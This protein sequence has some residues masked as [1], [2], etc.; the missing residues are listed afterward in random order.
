M[1]GA[2]KREVQTTLGRRYH[3]HI[4]S[5]SH[6]QQQQAR[7]PNGSAGL[8]VHS[9]EDDGWDVIERLDSVPRRHTVRARCS[10]LAAAPAVRCL[11]LALRRQLAG[12]L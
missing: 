8:V 1:G 12:I 2:V 4:A 11:R 5:S 6:G 10:W 9:A 3:R 7:P